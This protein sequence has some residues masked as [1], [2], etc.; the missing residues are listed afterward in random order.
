MRDLDEV[1][2]RFDVVGMD[3]DPATSTWH[4]TLIRDAFQ[5]A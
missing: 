1:A 2:C 3:R 4:F 5:S